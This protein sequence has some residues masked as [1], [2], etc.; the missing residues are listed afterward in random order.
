MCPQ[1]LKCDNCGALV[2][3]GHNGWDCDCGYV[4][5]ERTGFEWVKLECIPCCDYCKHY[6]D[7]GGGPGK[8]GGFAGYGLCEIHNKE[9]LA[10][11]DCDKF[12]CKICNKQT[13]TDQCVCK[14]VYD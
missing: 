7:A 4:C 2:M 13:V 12:Y 5:N 11:S 9:V 3:E 8:R 1:V 6:K 10:S 14:R